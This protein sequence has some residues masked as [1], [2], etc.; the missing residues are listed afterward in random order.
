MA[1]IDRTLDLRGVDKPEIIIGLVGA[2][3]APVDQVSE[4]LKSAVHDVG[5]DAT[6]IRLSGFLKA[7]GSLAT[8][9]PSQNAAAEERYNR[10]MS[11]GDELRAKLGRGD[12]LA[13][14]AA[15]EIAARRELSGRGS[16]ALEG[17]AFILRQLKHPAE[18]QLLRQI[19]GDAFHLVGIYTSEGARNEYLRNVKGIASTDANELIKRDAGE[20]I[21]HGQQVTKTYHL[22]DLFVAVDGWKDEHLADAAAQIRRYFDL[23]FGKGIVTPTIEEYGMYL[24]QAAA[25]RSADLSRQ[26]G[27]AILSQE[28]EVL[29]LG[30]NE[31]PKA[32]GGQYW[33]GDSDDRDFVRGYDSN[34]VL[35]LGA[36]E[37]VVAHLTPDWEKL[38]GQARDKIIGI[39]ASKLANSR[40]MNLTEF[41]RA[42]HAEMEALLSAVRVG[43][44]VRD[45]VLYTTTFPCHN[46]AKH[47]VGAGI[48]NVIYVE[49]Y[50]KSLADYLHGDAIGFSLDQTS[51]SETDRV[52]FRSFVGVAPRR[53]SALFSM[54][55]PDGQKI[56]RKGR[57]GKILSG[58]ASLRT[59][60]TPLSHVDREAMVAAYLYEVIEG[61]S[62]LTLELDP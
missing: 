51:T 53:F 12:A 42:V 11:R 48:R 5:Y 36:V 32:G 8:P 14:H 1:E 35:K 45:S 17:Q 19:Y 47:I 57:G 18:V 43:Q 31:V 39:A 58:K 40:L 4:L 15:A 6:E 23:M 26:V 46:C 55:G 54:V 7:Y 3:G 60:A 2:L 10:L 13:M 29:A 52:H 44:S 33:G 50:P 16:R 62:Q 22:S 20:Q 9:D 49:P 25:F 27:A 56:R 61:L 37:E 34:E 28:G 41:G 38:D 24:A 59:F 21:T 30:A